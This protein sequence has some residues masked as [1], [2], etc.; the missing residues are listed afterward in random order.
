M[1]LDLCQN[2]TNAQNTFHKCPMMCTQKGCNLQMTHDAQ[3][4]TSWVTNTKRLSQAYKMCFANTKHCCHTNTKC[5]ASKKGRLTQIETHFV[6][7]IGFTY[8][9]FFFMSTQQCKT[10]VN[11]MTFGPVILP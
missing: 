9:T 7:I 8:T 11:P 10:F 4:C 2:V 3:M 6:C 5:F 1:E